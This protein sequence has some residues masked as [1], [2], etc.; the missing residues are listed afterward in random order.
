[1]TNQLHRTVSTGGA[2]VKRAPPVFKEKCAKDN[3]NFVTL[4]PLI[5]ASASSKG[6]ELL[7]F[8]GTNSP[9]VCLVHNTKTDTYQS[10][11]I[12]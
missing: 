8:V 2:R 4:H 6:L 9:E 1:M 10:R 7:S 5:L 3:L 12:Y 11:R